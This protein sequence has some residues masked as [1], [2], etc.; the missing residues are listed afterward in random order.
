MSKIFAGL[1]IVL[2]GVCS[3]I[4]AKTPAPLWVLWVLWFT[5]FC[6]MFSLVI[7][8]LSWVLRK[9]AEHV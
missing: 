7:E 9:V 1:V 4:A 8:V 3:Y 5:S 6:S 2:A